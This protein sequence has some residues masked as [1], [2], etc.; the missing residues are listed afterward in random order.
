MAESFEYCIIGGGIVGAWAAY[1]LSR[2]GASLVLCEQFEFFHEK[3]SSHGESRITRYSYDH[4]VY[5]QMAKIGYRLW[6]ELSQDSKQELFLKTGG[7]DLEDTAKTGQTDSRIELCRKSLEK[8]KVDFELLDCREIQKRFPQFRI[9]KTTRA[10]YQKDAGILP[11][12]L[13]LKTLLETAST[14]YGASLLET[15]KVERL[16]FEGK[17]IK[18]K[19]SSLDFKAKKL[20]IACGAWS[21][22]LLRG[23]GF[24]LP[25][26]VSQEQYAFFQPKNPAA[27]MPD[28]FPVFIQNG[29][30]E[31]G[32]MSWYGFPIYGLEGI[33]SSIH[34]SGK[35]VSTAGRDF[36][37]D[38]EKLHEVENLLKALLPDAH[39]PII[40]ASTCLYT[41]SKDKHF[42]IDRLPGKENAVFFAGGSGHAFKFGPVIAEALINLL[43]G[44]KIS[45]PLEIFRK[46]RF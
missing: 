23:L 8:E 19:S 24:K 27:F 35:I 42:V 40:K 36:Q 26:S 7:L 3:G 14:K 17:S 4:P 32:G 38:Q 43:D 11:A 6:Q 20:I 44:S 10:L 39:G 29:A 30:A 33:K 1:L 2:R 22:S 21:E 18:I 46:D 31:A 25:L 41:S 12:S 45:F 34:M 9:S 15:S 37:V 13:S 5:V 16:E 28:R